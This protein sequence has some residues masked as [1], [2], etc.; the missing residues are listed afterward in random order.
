MTPWTTTVFARVVKL[1]DEPHGLVVTAENGPTLLE[2]V[3]NNAQAK[4]ELGIGKAIRATI[5]VTDQ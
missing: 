5:E 3:C 1:S 2:F 4:R